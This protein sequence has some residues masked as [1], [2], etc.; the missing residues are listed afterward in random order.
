MN[1][2]TREKS[3]FYFV[4]EGEEGIY[5]HKDKSGLSLESLKWPHEHLKIGLVWILVRANLVAQIANE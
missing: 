5:L 2:L 4:V 1:W 3:S